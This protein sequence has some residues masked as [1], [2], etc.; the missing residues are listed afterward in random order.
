MLVRGRL[1]LLCV[2]LREICSGPGW[3]ACALVFDS[4]RSDGTWSDDPELE[5]GLA[6]LVLAVMV[7]DVANQLL[8]RLETR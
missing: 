7:T 6:A 5:Q 8:D 4:R 3:E 1:N 2:G